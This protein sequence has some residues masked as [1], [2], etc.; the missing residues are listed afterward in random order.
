MRGPGELTYVERFT[1]ARVDEVSR[2]EEMPGRRNGRHRYGSI[3]VIV[4][5]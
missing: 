2:A 1:V 5:L 4:S 3:R